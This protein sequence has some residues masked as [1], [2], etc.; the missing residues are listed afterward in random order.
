M[1]LI[2][3]RSLSWPAS[4]ATATPPPTEIPP[5]GPS[6]TTSEAIPVIQTLFMSSP[7]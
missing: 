7:D 4:A 6:V 1:A 2:G 5:H 3:A